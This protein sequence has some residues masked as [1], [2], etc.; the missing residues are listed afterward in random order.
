[1]V[2]YDSKNQA[3]VSLDYHRDSSFF[4]SAIPDTT[5]LRLA[6]QALIQS[7]QP[8]YATWWQPKN[9]KTLAKNQM[10]Q[11]KNTCFHVHIVSVDTNIR[12]WGLTPCILNWRSGSFIASEV[13]RRVFQDNGGREIMWEYTD[14]V[15]LTR[16]K[17]RSLWKYL[18]YA[19]GHDSSRTTL[20][21]I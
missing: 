17:V 9:Q 2:I 16:I 20:E 6:I 12:R 14:F 10:N 7:S 1:M 5:R 15:A 3:F 11:F 18:Q 13:R 8:L 21:C 4:Y 19:G